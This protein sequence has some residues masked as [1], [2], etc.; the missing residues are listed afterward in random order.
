[1]ESILTPQCIVTPDN[2]VFS[3]FVQFT[4]INSSQLLCKRSGEQNWVIVG[5]THQ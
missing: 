3:Q 5:V 4:D 2:A 1:M